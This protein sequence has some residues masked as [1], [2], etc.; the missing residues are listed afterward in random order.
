MKQFTQIQIITPFGKFEA[1]RELVENL[2][3]AKVTSD[4]GLLMVSGRHSLNMEG[5]GCW[6]VIPPEI[7]LHSIAL[8]N[9]E[10]LASAKEGLLNSLADILFTTWQE[11]KEVPLPEGDSEVLDV[12]YASEESFTLCKMQ[13]KK[14]LDLLTNRGIITPGLT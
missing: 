2:D 1:K 7:L 13:A 8:V 5:D 14:L 3:M 12:A 11:M 6:C 9:I 10:D 4:L